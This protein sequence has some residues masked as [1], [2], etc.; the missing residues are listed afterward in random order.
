[1]HGCVLVRGRAGRLEGLFVWE[2]EFSIF[3][4][5]WV[6]Y[7]WLVLPGE[8]Y[9]LARRQTLAQCRLSR[10]CLGLGLILML[11]SCLLALDWCAQ[12]CYLGCPGGFLLA[13]GRRLFLNRPSLC[14]TCQ[15]LLVH[16]GYSVGVLLLCLGPLLLCLTRRRGR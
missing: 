10:S 5:S 2:G 6:P 12:N 8:R 11:H 13:S 4:V 15:D 9:R 3:D 14:L 7:L 16:F 1:M